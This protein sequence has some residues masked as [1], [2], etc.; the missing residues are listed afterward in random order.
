MATSA[1]AVQLDL[2]ANTKPFEQESE[3]AAGRVKGMF[4]RIGGLVG[5][6]FAIGALVRFGNECTTVAS[7]L[8]EVQN[9]VDVV[10]PSM[11]SQINSWS[12]NLVDKFGLSETKAKQYAGTIGSMARSM[13]F[14]ESQAYEMSTAITELAGD[15]ASFYDMSSDEAYDKL[16]A[17]FTG[18]TQPLRQLGI[19]MTQATLDAYAMEHGFARTTAQ[20]SEAERTMLRF[21]FVQDRLRFAQ[22]DFER[23]SGSW[24]NQLRILSM[25]F[26]E[27]K[28]AVGNSLIMALTPAIRVINTIIAALT[29][30]ANAFYRFMQAISSSIIG[31]AVG[32]IGKAWGSLAGIAGGATDAVSGLAD[33]EDAVAGSAGG[34]AAAQDKLNR[35]LAGFDRI[36]KLS[37]SSSSGGG[38]GGGGG[39]VG[40]LDIGAMEDAAAA[41]SL[42][43]GVFDSF[44]PPEKLV[45][46]FEKL[47]EAFG[48]IAEIGRGALKWVWDN[49]LVPLGEWT[50]D[51]LAPAVVSTLASGLDALAATIEALQ[52]VWDIFW[53]KV[54]KPLSGLAGEAIV[55]IITGLGNAFELWAAVMDQVF[56]PAI[57]YAAEMMERLFD[58]MDGIHRLVH[59][60]NSS[61]TGKGGGFSLGGGG[62]AGDRQ[63]MG[64]ENGVTRWERGGGG[65]AFFFGN[66]VARKFAGLLAKGKSKLS[67]KVDVRNGKA[68]ERAAEAFADVRDRTATLKVKA[69]GGTEVDGMKSKL[70]SVTGKTVTLNAVDNVTPKIDAANSKNLENHWADLT[71]R[72]DQVTGKIDA[73]NSKSLNN[74]WADLY[75]TP[76]LTKNKI[77]M[78]SKGYGEIQLSAFAQG[79]FVERNSPRLA[80]I[81]DNTRE[82]EIVS[83]ESKFQNMLD[84]AAGT[85]SD[86]QVVQLLTQLLDVVSGMDT[87]VYIDGREVTRSVVSNIN[88]QTQSTGRNPLI[89]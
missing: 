10:F 85:R 50:M 66:P 31:K 34:A 67:V 22:G 28:V 14:T 49:V 13:G 55:R 78:T 56:N 77:T 35:A 21:Q 40:G 79:G 6:A 71:V 43:D 52:P 5:K 18:M 25:R 39:G 17:I 15:V 42:L 33:A 62:F 12:Q 38:G 57:K 47:S 11:N 64:T 44:Q 76:V 82:G 51:E 68:A 8:T 70:G 46:A 3:A 72:N 53:E 60:P 32:G 7:R 41:G 69:T 61:G 48:R 45:R 54:L 87:G 83:P 37:D 73:A 58:A 16:T 65:T 2:K 74:H 4:S 81:G 1:G 86:A 59:G 27:L 75:F 30:A 26:E 63:N 9:V 88:R 84:K 19:N 23:T 29:A 36:N 80:V 24:A 20:M 89:I